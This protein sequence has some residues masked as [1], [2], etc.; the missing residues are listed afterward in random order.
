LE[1][2]S[3]RKWETQNKEVLIQEGSEESNLSGRFFQHFT[4]DA[5][6][7]MLFFF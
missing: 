7:D 4:D 1:N 3:P 6:M 2:H 5:G